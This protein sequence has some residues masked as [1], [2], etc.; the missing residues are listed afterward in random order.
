MKENYYW[1]DK[2]VYKELKEKEKLTDTDIAELI[3][4]PYGSYK[5]Y[6][7]NRHKTPL[8][9]LKLLSNLFN[10]PVKNLTTKKPATPTRVCTATIEVSYLKLKN[11]LVERN[12]TRKQLAEDL[13]ISSAFLSEIKNGRKISP[14][15]LDKICRYLNISKEDLILGTNEKVPVTENVPDMEIN[16]SEVSPLPPVLHFEYKEF[17]SQN[18][19]ENMKTINENI[20][21]L[22]TAVNTLFE[23]LSEKDISFK[24]LNDKLDDFTAR[25][26]NDFNLLKG[27]LK[28]IESAKVKAPADNFTVKKPIAR[29]SDPILAFEYAKQKGNQNSLEEYKNKVN[30]M[31]T[32]ISKKKDLIWGQVAHDINKKFETTYGENITSLKKIYAKE[33]QLEGISDVTVTEAIYNNY[34]YRDIYY[35]IIADEVFAA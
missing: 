25:T 21:T 10:V 6:T 19:M 1:L 31:I 15:K 22:G 24:S 34:I 9:I 8:Y 7:A 12:I 35:N 3:S 27:I 33:H 14:E 32:Y 30:T 4:V 5:A 18:P 13:H 28:D 26:D 29:K 2:N 17:D 20:I 11:T 23:Q 16:E